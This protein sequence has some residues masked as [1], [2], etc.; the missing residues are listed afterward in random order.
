MGLAMAVIH[1]Q[2]KKIEKQGLSRR[3]FLR[4][5]L[6]TAGS[7]SA[8]QW[9][10]ACGS[11][12][13]SLSGSAV[14]PSGGGAPRVSPFASMGP[15]MAPDANGVQLPAGFTSRVVAVFN[16]PPLPSQPDFRWHSDPDGG[17]IFAT[18]DGGWIYVSNSEARDATTAFGQIPDELAA[19]RQLA[20]R[21]SLAALSPVTNAISGLVNTL[22]PGGI[23]LVLPFAGGASALRFD[24][25]G[26]LIDAYPV[27]RNTTTN[28]SGGA[29][30]WGTWI[31]GEEIQDGF[32]FECSPLRD[33][34]EPVRL[35]RFGRKAHEQVA[36]DV[37]RRAIY[38][39]E[40]ITGEDRFYRT[41]FTSN[42]W[43]TG[44]RPDF[45]KGKLQVL[46]VPA[47]IDA[48]RQGPTPINWLDAIDDGRPQPD[49]YLPDATIFAGNEGV[50]FLNGFV[51]FSTKVDSNVW[52][53]D[54]VNGTIESIYD[55]TDGPIGSP[56]DPAEP[57]MMGVDNLSMTLDG[58]MI[59]VEDGGSMRAMVLLPDRTTIPLLRLPG[60]AGATEVTGPAFSP[61]GRRLYVANQRALRNGETTQ[62]GQGGVVYEITMPF[63]V[64]V[65]PPMARPM[66]S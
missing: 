26:N 12:S 30:P 19:I 56:V 14:S 63:T 54:V 8:A 51:Y 53:I 22:L 37:G 18:E 20:S 11:D 1:D 57:R 29:S 31:N 2:L 38:H 48:A 23:P 65:N 41:V 17:A 49:V 47:G 45:S 25:D 32:M 40:D 15:L 61:D 24:R 4:N 66:P 13:S 62:T 9:L 7:I 33:G 34:G 60:D 52:A 16:E 64:R 50:W 35:D 58:E 36:F 3:V 28:C 10:T 27:Q 55:P 6:L 42:D 46:S 39:T 21:D 44:A 5:M 43:P 59:V